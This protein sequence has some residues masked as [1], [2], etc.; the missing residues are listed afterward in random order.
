[1]KKAEKI[2]GIIAI[3]SLL[4]QVFLLPG[5]NVLT[6]LSLT[7]LSIIYFNLGFLLFNDI[8]LRDAFKKSSYTGISTSRKIGALVTGI[9]LSMTTIGLMF[10]F[11]LWPGAN[12]MI[13]EGFT[14][15]VIISVVALIKYL[16][17]RSNYYIGIFRRAVIFGSIALVFIVSPYSSWIDIKYRKHPAYRDALKNANANPENQALWDKVQEE[18]EKMY[19]EPN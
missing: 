19:N 17:N 15:L 5:G 1:M 14:P 13:V 11:Q 4:M 12:I 10:K 6:V 9:A 3:L 18:K 2:I 16:Q 8:R 7:A